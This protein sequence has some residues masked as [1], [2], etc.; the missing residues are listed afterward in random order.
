MQLLLAYENLM[1]FALW[2]QQLIHPLVIVAQTAIEIYK[3]PFII[4][5]LLLQSA[6][7]VL[8][9]NTNNNN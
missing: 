2:Q 4:F 8:C 1:A 7:Y 5:F 9:G 6:L 3:M